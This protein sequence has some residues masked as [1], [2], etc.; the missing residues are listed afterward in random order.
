MPYLRLFSVV[1]V[2]GCE[3]AILR[4]RSY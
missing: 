1:K 2:L 4:A 3:G